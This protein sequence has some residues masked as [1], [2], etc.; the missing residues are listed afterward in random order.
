MFRS[1][2]SKFILAF[3]TLI[4]LLFTVLGL[5]LVDAKTQELSLDISE[6][7]QSFS[8]LT[9]AKMV[10]AYEQYLKPGNYLAFSRELSSLLRQNT[11]ISDVQITSYGGVVLY[12]ASQEQTSRYEGSL[13]TVT[14]ASEI[15]RI[16]ANKMSLLLDSGRVVYVKTDEDKQVSYVNFNENPVEAPLPS[17]RVLDIVVPY[18]NAYA[19]S[20]RV[21]YELME[22][23]LAAAKMQIGIFALVGMLLTLLLSYMLSVSVTRPLKALK[24]GALKLA[25][26]DF[27]TRVLV[28]GKDEVGVL[29][30]TFNQMANDLAAALEVRLYKERVV[31]EL[32]LAAKIQADLLPKERVE[33]PSLDL[34]GGLDPATEIGGDAFDFIP[35]ASGETLI[36]LGDV[37]GHGVPAGILSSIANGL[38]YSLRDE[39]NLKTLALSL[40]EV[41]RKK[42][43]SAMFMSM[44]LTRW[45]PV[46]GRLAYLNAGHLPLLHY[47][48]KGKKVT[49]V[50]LPGIAFGMVDDIENLLQV[51]ELILETGDVVVL[52]SDGFPEAQNE[53][54]E[55]YG[56]QRLRRIVQQAGD[57]LLTAE[58]VK[59]AV[60]ADVLQYIGEQNHL[61][62]ITIVVMKRK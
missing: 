46:T 2:K 13:R 19:L 24:E 45:N 25:T 15:E 12:V 6:G 14:Q 21:T 54:H 16:Q 29:A 47:S 41:I 38:I 10:E 20:Y 57:D 27:T 23:R 59:N 37:S 61:D 1:L 36:Y 18:G 34:A 8:E 56:M 39:S 17:E 30:S 55:Q 3:G 42:S 35:T 9:A 43:S 52:Y 48:A 44:G 7:S 33:L 50:K 49:E 22:Q 5:F 26:G 58:G 31:K 11:S 32:E 40:N 4:L 53:H 28:K 51:Q 62:D 60:F